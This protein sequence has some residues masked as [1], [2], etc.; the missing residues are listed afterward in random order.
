MCKDKFDNEEPSMGTWDE[1]TC[2]CLKRGD[3]TNIMNTEP[4]DIISLERIKSF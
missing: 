3:S 1:S 4:Y 2:K